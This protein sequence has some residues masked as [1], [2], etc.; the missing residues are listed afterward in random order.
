MTRT[1]SILPLR[2]DHVALRNRAG[3]NRTLARAVAALAMAEIDGLTFAG[4]LAERVW[5]DDHNVGLVLRAATTPAMTSTPTWAGSLAA[6]VL[7]D[8]IVAMGPASAGAALLARGLQLTFAGA[9]AIMVPGLVAAAGTAAFVVEGD[10]I[11]ARRLSLAGPTLSPHKFACIVPFTR[12]IFQYSTPTI[13]A[14]ITAGLTEGVGLDLDFA[15][16]DA[17]AASPARSAGLRNGIATIGTAS[18][19]T[20]ISEAVQADVA[21]L[22]ASVSVIAGNGAIIIVAAPQQA[23]RLRLWRSDFYYPVLASSGLSNGTVI[24]I[25]ANALVS[26]LDPVPRISVS[27]QATIHD[28]TV[29]AQIGTAGVVAAPTQSLWDTDSIGI[30]LIM[31]VA[32]GLRNSA[33]LAWLANVSW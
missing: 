19:A 9:G 3:S 14:L 16:L 27:N 5:P 25:A 6:T 7:S 8:F 1:P 18:T 15:L 22:I 23:A 17:N 4:D 31:E 21:A 33:A 2:V 28:D 32:W 11:P 29:P 20:P 30:R 24:A 26:A 10:P 13:E 12:E